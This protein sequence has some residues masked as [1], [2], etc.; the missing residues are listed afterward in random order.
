MKTQQLNFP[1]VD[2]QE[3]NSPLKV[4]MIV[5]SDAAGRLGLRF[6]FFLGGGWGPQQM[7]FPVRDTAGSKFVG[8]KI[9]V[10]PPP[11]PPPAAAERPG[12]FINLG[13]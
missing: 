12:S 10:A 8:G 1:S 4:L 13:Y 11:P 7:A 2:S 6:L 9:K 3:S 5:V